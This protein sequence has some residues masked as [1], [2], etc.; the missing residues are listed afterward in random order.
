MD[1]KITVQLIDEAVKCLYQNKEKEA[2]QKVSALLPLFENMAKERA[3]IQDGSV[4]YVIR[5]MKNLI[6][7]YNYADMIGM[8]DCLKEVAYSLIMKYGLEC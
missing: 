4:L 3:E 8:A 1:K 6:E 7:N 5:F 2:M